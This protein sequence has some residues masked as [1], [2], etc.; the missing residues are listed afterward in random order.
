MTNYCLD[1]GIIIAFFKNDEKVVK[2]MASLQEDNHIF[3][4]F[5]TLCELYKG[6]YRSSNINYEMSFLNNLTNGLS[7]CP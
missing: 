2:R 3:I 1:T 5:I 6:V 7:Q 4:T